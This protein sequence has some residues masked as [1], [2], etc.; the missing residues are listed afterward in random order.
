MTRS[1]ILPLIAALLAGTAAVAQDTRAPD[2][3]PRGGMIGMLDQ[4]GDGQIAREE[5]EAAARAR[6]AETNANG[7][8]AVSQEEFV[9]RAQAR[10]AERAAGMFGRIDGDGDGRIAA[11][12]LPGPS[13]DRIL[14]MFDR[15]D[16][17]GDGTVT[18][19]EIAATDHHGKGH[20]P[21]YRHHGG[22]G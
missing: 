13:T 12:D 15:M 9:A 18:A 5:A 20:G 8:G 11:A 21:H 3:G 6:F 22:R 1:F 2:G 17:D 14:R 10:A 4:D 16:A 19:E 7:D